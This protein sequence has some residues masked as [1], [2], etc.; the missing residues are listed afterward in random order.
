MGNRSYLECSWFTSDLTLEELN[1]LYGM[2]VD[3]HPKK[4]NL[5]CWE[6]EEDDD[7]FRPEGAGRWEKG[8]DYLELATFIAMVTSTDV[9]MRITPGEGDPWGYMIY[10]GQVCEMKLMPGKIEYYQPRRPWQMDDRIKDL[11]ERRQG[12]KHDG[13]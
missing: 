8:Y 12:E 13:T 5:Q 11:L 4:D 1:D 3:S 9:A 6:F 7:K 2:Y 10:P